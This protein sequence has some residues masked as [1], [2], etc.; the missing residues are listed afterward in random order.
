LFSIGSSQERLSR[1]SNI[2]QVLKT[3][4]NHLL[5]TETVQEDIDKEY[6]KDVIIERYR[7]IGNPDKV[8]FSRG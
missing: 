5:E 4:K 8:T 1:R 2:V 3:F 6:I 7:S